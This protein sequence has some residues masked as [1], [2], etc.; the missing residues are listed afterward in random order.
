LNGGIASGSARIGAFLALLLLLLS[1]CANMAGTDFDDPE[2][3][4]LSLAPANSRGMEAR[5]LV[6]LRIVNPN[7]TPLSID[8][9]AYEVYL[10]DSRIL[11]GVSDQPLEV[12]AFSETTAKLEVAAGMLSS[13]ALLRDLMASPPGESIPYRL[14][15]K[16]SRPGLGG[17]L[18]ISREGSIEMGAGG[19]GLTP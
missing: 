9:M 16:L 10:R 14:N 12:G 15:A 17:T 18:R 5:F 13:L 2:V 1:G 7:R 3:E 19:R 6:T 11:S 8:G 4:L